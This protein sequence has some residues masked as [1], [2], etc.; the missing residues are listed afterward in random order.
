MFM[1]EVEQYLEE[2]KK[3]ASDIFQACYLSMQ[4]TC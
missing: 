4:D 1:F 3:Y 2:L